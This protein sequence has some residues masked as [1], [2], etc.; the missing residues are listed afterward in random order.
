MPIGH[1]RVPLYLRGKI[2]I[3]ESVITPAGIDNEQEGFGHNAGS[4]RH[5]YRIAVPLTEIWS[6]STASAPANSP[7][8]AVHDRLYIEV[9]ENWLERPA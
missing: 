3:V 1:Y 7:V 2:G 9:F 4:R 8:T 6:A 5:Y